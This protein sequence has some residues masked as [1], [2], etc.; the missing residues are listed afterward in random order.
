MLKIKAEEMMN[1]EIHICDRYR[2]HITK[3]TIS[4]KGK[5]GTMPKRHN[6][7][8]SDTTG[9]NASFERDSEKN[10][11]PSRNYES[12][13]QPVN[14]EN[15]KLANKTRNRSKKYDSEIVQTLPDL[16]RESIGDLKRYSVAKNKM[17][18]T[19]A[20]FESLMKSSSRAVIEEIFR[21]NNKSTMA[22]S[23]IAAVGFAKQTGRRS[24]VNLKDNAHEDRFNNIDKFPSI[25]STNKK[26]N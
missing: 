16:D 11:S 2:D 21:G 24:L 15:L 12:H 8:V 1:K 3:H 26:T 18:T 25:L 14:I 4:K 10:N 19:L 23:K 5:Y 22:N 9:L 7:S 17:L 13:L 20:P 6:H